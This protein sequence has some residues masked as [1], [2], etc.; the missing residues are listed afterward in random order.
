MM[1]RFLLQAFPI[2][3]KSPHDNLSFSKGMAKSLHNSHSPQLQDIG[4]CFLL[5]AISSQDNKGPDIR[6]LTVSKQQG[7][8]Y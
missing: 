8:T 6:E 3:T 5:M 1:Y 2:Y 7:L 4:P